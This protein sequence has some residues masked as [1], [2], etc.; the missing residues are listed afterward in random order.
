[1]YSSSRNSRD[2]YR[3]YQTSNGKTQSQEQ[4]EVDLCEVCDNPKTLPSIYDEN[5]V[6]IYLCEKCEMRKSKG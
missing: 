4:K 6:L 1:M 5:G 2:R 3:S